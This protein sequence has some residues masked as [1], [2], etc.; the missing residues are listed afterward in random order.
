LQTWQRLLLSIEDDRSPQGRKAFVPG[1]RSRLAAASIR[2]DP[3]CAEAP[4]SAIDCHFLKNRT[5]IFAACKKN[6]GV[7]RL[8]ADKLNAR[9]CRFFLEARR[10]FWQ[11]ARWR[12]FWARAIGKEA[13]SRRH[14]VRVSKA[15]HFAERL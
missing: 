8:P 12:E 13:E 4:R 2:R 1:G 14:G 10:A 15:G 6:A 5:R 3:R 11:N 9:I 7:I